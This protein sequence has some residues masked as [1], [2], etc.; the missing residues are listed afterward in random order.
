MKSL[1]LALLALTIFNG[2]AARADNMASVGIAPLTGV[3]TLVPRWAIGGNLGGFHLMAQDT[4]FSVGPNNFY[5]VK[6]TAIPQGGDIAA[7]T[8]YIA[9]SGAATDHH[10]VG[11]KLTPD[12][13]SALTSADPDVGYGAVNFY[14]IHH[15]GITDYLAEIVPGSGTAS[16]VTDLKPMSGPGGPATVTGVGGYFG[17]TFAAANL[18]YGLNLFYYLRSDPVTGFTKFGTLAPGLLSGSADQFGL[19][20]SGHRAL[21]FTGSDV[22]FGTNQM[23]FLR[24]DPVTGFTILGTLH[25]L[26][27]KAADIANLG[28][29]YATLDFVAG[30]VGFGVNRFYVTG[31][32]N[33][34]WQ[35]VSF[36]AIADRA[37]TAGSFTVTPRPAPPCRSPSPL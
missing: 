19:G 20:L 5:S 17:L 33:P 10:D 36:A 7:F 14:F 13:Y 23:Y 34:T 2:S 12:S 32:V 9:A 37:F 25:P 29:V 26:T 11:S 8:Y 21:T 15:K 35:S 3:V 18:G 6:N 4:G 31:V 24:L 30:D 27:G 16:A 22:G 1:T 28:S